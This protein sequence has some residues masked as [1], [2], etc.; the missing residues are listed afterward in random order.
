MMKPLR[1]VLYTLLLIL[2]GFLAVTALLG[3]IGILMGFGAP[4]VD[5]VEGSIFTDFTVPA[6][7][8][9]FIVGGSGLLA[10]VALLRKSRFGLLLAIFAGIMILFFEFV[11]VLAIGSPAGLAQNLQIFYFGLGTAIVIVALGVWYID[12]SAI[13]VH[14]MT[15][16]RRRVRTT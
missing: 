4:V 13:E 16:H 1:K 9:I 12:L 8:L 7:S 15:T 10:T 3:G 2:T 6:L 11:E 5:F 14:P